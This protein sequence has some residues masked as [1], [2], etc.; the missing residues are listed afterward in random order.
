[1]NRKQVGIA[2]ALAVVLLGGAALVLGW[3]RV[4][5]MG[6]D[7]EVFHSVDALFTAVTARDARLLNQCERRLHA[8]RD[9]GKLP[10]EASRYLDGVVD[11]ARNG[12]WESAAQDLYDFMTKQRREGAGEPSP[13][14]QKSGGAPRRDARVSR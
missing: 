3:G 9:A 13:R 2:S 10:A 7:D 1:M 6:A 14:K 5:Q 12:R 8:H 11:R 4:P